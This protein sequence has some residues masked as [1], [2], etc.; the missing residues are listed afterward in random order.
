[1]FLLDLLID[2]L[3]PI[4]VAPSLPLGLIAYLGL[5]FTPS[6]S[7]PFFPKALRGPDPTDLDEP[8]EIRQSQQ[9]RARPR[10]LVAV[11]HP[12]DG[13]LYFGPAITRLTARQGAGKPEVF[14]LSLSNGSAKSNAKE[15]AATREKEF[16]KSCVSLGVPAAN[17]TV[18]ND[19]H[20]QDGMT[21][22]WRDTDVA[23]A[24][25][26]FCG[27]HAI[28]AVRH[29]IR[30]S[31][32]APKAYSLRSVSLL[33]TYTS[34]IDLA[35]TLSSYLIHIIMGAYHAMNAKSATTG[36]YRKTAMTE[37]ALFLASPFEIVRIWDAMLCHKSQLDRYRWLYMAFSRYTLMN[38]LEA[39]R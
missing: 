31:K 8:D 28:T 29:L 22:W 26:K 34:F 33:R 15:T 27:C 13:S 4:A 10:I 21:S 12:E 7:L 20:M 25:S 36:K 2:W 32:D 30:H 23:N 24:I 5:Q 1:M 37:R 3:L 9:A 17:A 14:V 39:I 11:A 18:L 19:P 16:V 6:R 35:P 38:E